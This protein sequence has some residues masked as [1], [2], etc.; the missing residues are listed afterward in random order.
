MAAVRV[1]MLAQRSAPPAVGRQCPECS[2]P[3]LQVDWDHGETVCH[4]CGLIVEDRLAQATPPQAFSAEEWEEKLHTGAPLTFT[5]KELGLATM[6][7]NYQEI[8]RLPARKRR[9]YQRL[10]RLQQQAVGSRVGN[11][12]FALPELR[13]MT[14]ELDLSSRV[15]EEAARLY[16]HAAHEGY[17][18]GRR[19]EHVLGGILYIV[20]RNQ[21]TPRTLDEIADT[22]G[23]DESDIGAASRHIAR[24]LDLHVLPAAPEDYLPRLASSVQ[25]P[26]TVQATGRQIIHQVTAAGNLAGKEPRGVAAAALY[27]ALDVHDQDRS[28]QAFSDQVAVSTTTLRKR[29]NEFKQTIDVDALHQTVPQ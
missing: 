11:M 24:N 20:A 17:V 9:Q 15:Q 21:R 6:I 18:Q 5:Q 2:S 23:G 25:A 7:G 19:I 27:L 1:Y 3:R 13:R 22:T 29:I 8:S 10:Q 14:A 12:R 28:V 4:S 26:G 16:H